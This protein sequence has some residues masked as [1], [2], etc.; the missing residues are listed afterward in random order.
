MHRLF[1]AP[2]QIDITAR[3]AGITGQDHQHLTR[4]LR[5]RIG[6]SIV[7]L[8]G[9]GRAY[10]AEV[11]EIS[12]SET[13]VRLGAAVTP[14]PEPFIHI[15]VAQALGKS[16]KFEI[17]VQHGTEAGASKFVP[18]VA[19]RSVVEIPNDRIE[20]RLARWRAIAK[21][22][23]EQSF[24]ACIPEIVAP[25]NLNK[26]ITEAKLANAAILLLHTSAECVSLYE[27]L[28]RMPS[29][30]ERAVLC[31]GPEGGWSCGELDLASELGIEPVSLGP[32]VLR[33]ETAA[34]VAISRLI[35][36]FSKPGEITS[37][38]S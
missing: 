19:E 32:H 25:A 31:V 36:H 28:A 2:E 7:V 33:T 15:A 26:V 11:T 22:A 27:A 30:P 5:A 3:R 37:C 4:V 6:D 35:H 12:R 8:D 24:R 17:V 38:V 9:H 10:Q 20:P 21:G 16:D 18:V 23:A 34:L 1:L 14:P 29:A 13:V